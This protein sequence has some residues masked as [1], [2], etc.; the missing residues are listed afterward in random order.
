MKLHVTINGTPH[1]LDVAPGAILGDVLRDLGLTGLKL[2]CREGHCGSCM[3]LVDGKPLNSC[4]VLA[5]KVEDSHI[6]TIEGLG[7]VR[8]PHPIQ[9]AFVE[10]GA[11][12]CG[13]C[14]PGMIITIKALFDEN[15][16]PSPERIREALTSNLCRCT[17]YVKIFDAIRRAEE[18]LAPTTRP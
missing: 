12:Q 4:L 17:G 5:A 18:K 9:Q 1:T 16:H 14:T 8:H 6:V 10:A 2:G 7:D 13:F 11:V 15:P 3:V